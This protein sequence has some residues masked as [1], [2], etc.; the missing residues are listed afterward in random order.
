MTTTGTR[1]RGG[2]GAV[3]PVAHVSGQLR[4]EV[5]QRM[6]DGDARGVRVAMRCVCSKRC[7]AGGAW[8]LT[9]LSSDGL[10]ADVR[11][12]VTLI[13]RRRSAARKPAAPP[14]RTP[15]GLEIDGALS[16]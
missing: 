12:K 13:E 14:I 8:V 10:S 2:W 5:V 3:S 11:T 6:R 7:E 1:E 9:E 16:V 15:L 4:Q